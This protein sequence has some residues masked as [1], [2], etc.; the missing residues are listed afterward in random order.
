[1]FAIY[2]TKCFECATKLTDSMLYLPHVFSVFLVCRCV[3]TKTS[4]NSRRKVL[5]V[6]QYLRPTEELESMTWYTAQ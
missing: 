5:H 6:N 3:L 2:D 1:M 4:H